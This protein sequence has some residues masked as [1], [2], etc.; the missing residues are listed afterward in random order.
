VGPF[1]EINMYV[2]SVRVFLNNTHFAAY[3]M[4][5]DFSLY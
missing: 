2:L 1:G 5:L 4:H 3:M